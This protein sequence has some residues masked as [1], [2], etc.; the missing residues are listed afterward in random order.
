MMQVSRVV[1]VA[2]AEVSSV[3]VAL[4]LKDQEASPP[5]K[6]LYVMC[7]AGAPNPTLSVRDA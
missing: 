7:Y 1:G 3:V 2:Q 6:Q 4:G 5:N